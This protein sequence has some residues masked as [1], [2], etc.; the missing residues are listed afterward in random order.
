MS[1]LLGGDVRVLLS[2]LWQ[3][4][5]IGKKCHDP[6]S[7]LELEYVLV[8]LVKI[9]SLLA[10]QGQPSF[11]HGPGEEPD[12]ARIFITWHISAEIDLQDL[13]FVVS[14]EFECIQ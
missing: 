13:Q 11:D 9:Q 1:I 14:L 3:G 4:N 2:Q 6:Y 5:Y 12:P 7:Q 8:T 10:Y